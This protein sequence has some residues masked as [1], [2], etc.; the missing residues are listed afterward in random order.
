[1]LMRKLLYPFMYLL[2]MASLCIIINKASACE[3]APGA[4]PSYVTKDLGNNFIQR[5]APVGTT[6]L[7]TT[8]ST[9]R[10]ASTPFAP[11][12]RRGIDVGHFLFMGGIPVPGFDGYYQTQIPGV[13]INVSAGGQFTYTNPATD[14]P[15]AGDA[16]QTWSYLTW[17]SSYI[18]TLKKTGNIVSGPID[19]KTIVMSLDGLGT[20]LQLDITGGMVTQLACSIN[21]PNLNFPIGDVLASAF[22]SSIGFTPSVAQ[23]TQNL[24][25]NCDSGAKI[26]ISLEGIQNPDVSN[27][28][29]LALTNQG[30]S[31]VAKGVGV[32]ILYNG[33]PLTLNANIPV[34]TSSGGIEMLPITARYYQTKTSVTTGKANASATINLTYQ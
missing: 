5:D 15:T 12:C 17:G 31:D 2:V 32:Q 30:N 7:Q 27:G 34:K 18:V 1:M 23:N 10:S 26:N 16:V 19:H 20:V 28:T 21:T 25:L 4:S 22:G 8:F 24:G 33:T 11:N 3:W 29:V 9:G 6:I 14:V 13:G